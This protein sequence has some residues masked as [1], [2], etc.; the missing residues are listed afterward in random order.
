MR[1]ES[2]ENLRLKRHQKQEKRRKATRNVFDEFE[3]K[4]GETN[5]NKICVVKKQVLLK[6][7]RQEFMENHDCTYPKRIKHTE[8]DDKILLIW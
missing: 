2:Q 5:K 7:I 8:K 6:V 3:K 1:K 4:D